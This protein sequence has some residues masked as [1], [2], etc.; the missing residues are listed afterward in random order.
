MR[1]MVKKM[2]FFCLKIVKKGADLFTFSSCFDAF[3]DM[4]RV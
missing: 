4:G 3:F 1:Y 2:V